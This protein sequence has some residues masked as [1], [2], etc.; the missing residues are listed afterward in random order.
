MIEDIDQA[1]TNSLGVRETDGKLERWLYQYQHRKGLLA[2]FRQGPSILPAYMF[3]GTNSLF[4]CAKLIYS[5]FLCIVRAS[6]LET[7]KETTI[8]IHFEAKLRLL[9]GEQ[10]FQMLPF[11]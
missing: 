2:G 11:I 1:R 3:Q 9:C 8:E 7:P 10:A 6:W 4:N 5:S